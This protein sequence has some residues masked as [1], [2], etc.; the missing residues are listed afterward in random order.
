MRLE[1]ADAGHALDAMRLG[2]LEQQ[3]AAFNEVDELR[4]QLSA[5]ATQQRADR[6]HVEQA[7]LLLQA[8]SRAE[9]TERRQQ[10]QA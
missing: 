6:W 1:V 3:T 9:I 8:Q 10:Y 7:V 4:S 5:V 2:E